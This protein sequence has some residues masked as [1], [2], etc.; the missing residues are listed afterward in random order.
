MA[1]INL[2]TYLLTYAR[3]FMEMLKTSFLAAHEYHLLLGID[4]ST[5]ST[6]SGPTV[7]L[8]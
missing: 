7:K 4:I 1:E 2:L 6:L 3:I 5:A 8:D